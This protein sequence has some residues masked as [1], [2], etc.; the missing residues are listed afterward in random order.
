MSKYWITDY[1]KLV[2]MACSVF[3]EANAFAKTKS[4]RGQLDLEK[5]PGDAIEK[6]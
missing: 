1:H 4:A 2:C 6:L 3:C 5:E